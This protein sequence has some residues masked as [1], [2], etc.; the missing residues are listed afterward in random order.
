MVIFLHIYV[1]P[2]KNTVINS[3]VKL[4][5][6]NIHV[7][8]NKYKMIGMCLCWCSEW[9]LVTAKLFKLLTLVAQVLT[10]GKL[11]EIRAKR[12][13]VSEGQSYVDT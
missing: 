5:C 13:A 9:P 2:A 8:I 1:F 10:A 7:W 6:T 12:A 4:L 3:R 11:L